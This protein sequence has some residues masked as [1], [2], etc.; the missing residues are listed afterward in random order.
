MKTI[1]ILSLGPDSGEL[2]TL[3]ALTAMRTAKVLV[4]RTRRHA[5]AELLEREG[6][7]FETLD[8]LYEQSEDFDELCALAAKAIIFLSGYLL[9]PAK[10]S[11]RS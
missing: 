6:V 2:L 4:L 7:A 11:A 9:S 3:G 8:A 5:A 1:T 10:R